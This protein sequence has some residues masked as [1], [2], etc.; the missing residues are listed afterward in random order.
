[1]YRFDRIPKEQWEATVKAITE[2]DWIA[3]AKI[4]I[5]YDVIPDMPKC[6]TCINFEDLKNWS[7]YAIRNKLLQDSNA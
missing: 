4:Y 5:R 7:H 2:K 6:A 1:M 3:A